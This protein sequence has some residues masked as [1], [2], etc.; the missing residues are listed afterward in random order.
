MS[1]DDCSIGVV[2]TANPESWRGIV[3]IVLVHP[4]SAARDVVDKV[5]ARQHAWRKKFSSLVLPDGGAAGKSASDFRTHDLGQTLSAAGRPLQMV[6]IILDGVSAEDAGIDAQI[7]AEDKILIVCTSAAK[8]PGN[9]LF[10][11]HVWKLAEIAT[12]DCPPER[13]YRARLQANPLENSTTGRLQAVRSA[14]ST[15]TRNG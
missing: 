6:A 5:K 8:M 13:G 14:N 15:I 12:R 2:I 11:P 3:P 9:R 1:L 7:A 10:S 4:I